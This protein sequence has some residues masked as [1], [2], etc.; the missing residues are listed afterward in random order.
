MDDL[1]AVLV[2]G[3]WE[4]KGAKKIVSSANADWLIGQAEWKNYVTLTFRDPRFADVAK[5]Y[6]LRMVQILNKDAFGKRYVRKVG[7]SYFSYVLATEYQRREAIHFHVLADRPL[8][9]D[10]IHRWWNAAAGFAWIEPIE[11]RADVVRYC[12]KYC[13]KGGELDLFITD[14]SRTPMI[15]PL[16]PAWWI[17]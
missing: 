1:Q 16:P 2:A 8:N 12:S 3:G 6:Y 11:S 4:S 5:R 15:G 17:N 14:K 9:Y 10:L 13:V 7:H